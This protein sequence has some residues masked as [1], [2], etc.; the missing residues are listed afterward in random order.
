M[1]I[2]IWLLFLFALA[3]GF[4]LAGK[5][6][7]GYAILVYPP[8]RIE[9]SLTLF[10]FGLIIVLA[11]GE[12]I[13][14]FALTTLHLPRQARAFRLQR[15]RQAGQ[16]ALLEALRADIEQHPAACEAAAH[17]AIE[18]DYE[19]RLAALL[20]ARAAEAQHDPIKRDHYLELAKKF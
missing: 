17:R 19:P 11:A 7:P 4:T 10:V 1:R 2:L 16:A 3:V 12:L 15:R 14:R 8:W 20:A 5:F 13:M 9:L 6:N 18:M